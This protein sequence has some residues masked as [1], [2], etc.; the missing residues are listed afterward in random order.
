MTSRWAISRSGIGDRGGRVGGHAVPL[1]QRPSLAGRKLGEQGLADRG[2]VRLDPAAWLGEHPHRVR[3]GHLGDV[4]DLVAVEHGQVGRLA[5]EPDQLGQERPQPGTERLAG[6]LAEPDQPR[7]QRVPPRRLLP[8]VT[9]VDQ[10]PHQPV[11]GGQREPGDGGELGQ[12]E[13]AAGVGQHLEQV[14]GPL[15]GLHPARRS[16]GGAAG[17]LGQ[18]VHV[19]HNTENVIHMSE[20]PRRRRG[21][22]SA[23]DGSEVPRGGAGRGSA[24]E[25]RTNLWPSC[26]PEVDTT[27]GAG[28][29]TARRLTGCRP[30][31][32]LNP[33]HGKIISG[34]GKHV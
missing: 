33:R 8:D 29:R 32:S 18:I 24:R 16:R 22:G 2:A 15:D 19:F 27:R 28:E 34:Y 20:V 23:G 7:A 4:D 17:A 30:R 6:D 9:P 26:P 1:E 3:A 31:S 25:W 14:E 21:G 12:A 5:G 11:H 13:R 10:R